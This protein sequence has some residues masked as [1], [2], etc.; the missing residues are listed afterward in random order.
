MDKIKHFNTRLNWLKEQRKTHEPV[1]ADILDYIAP[2]LKGYLNG[3]SNDG[4]RKDEMDY[5][6]TPV[7]YNNTCAAGMHASV[8]SPSRPWFR[9][10]MADAALNQF[11]A[12]RI[13]L[14]DC[15]DLIYH[16]MHDSNFYPSVHQ[17]Y[18]HLAPIGTACMMIEKDY[19][20]VIHCR[21]LN[22][23]E[24]WIG[25]NA[26]SRV[27][28]L[29][30]EFKMTA[31]QLVE[32]FGDNVPKDIRN[33]LENDQNNEYTVVHAIEPDKLGIAPFKKKY[34]SVYYLQSNNNNEFLSVGG[35]D[36]LP[37]VA[38]RWGT[39]QGEAW[40]KFCPG[41]VSIGNCKQLQ[42][43]VYDFHEGLQKINNPPLQGNADAL[44]N[45]QVVGIPGGF[46]A[47]NSMGPDQSIKPLYQVNPDI[48]ATW[49][50][51]EDKKQQIANDFFVDLFQAV[52]QISQ[53]KEMTATEVREI[54]TERMLVLGPVLEN[55]QD[56]LLN[57]M[58][59]IIWH[60]AQEAG[61]LPEMPDNVAEV[62]SKKPIKVDYISSMASAQR[63]ADLARIDQILTV[64]SNAAKLNPEALDKIDVDEVIDQGDKMIGSPGGIIRDDETVAK[65]RQ[66]RQQQLEEQQRNQQLLQA[67]QT[68]QP[69]ATAAKTL[70]E[71]EN[72]GALETMLNGMGGGG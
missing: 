6:P 71:T 42:T 54:A 16:I 33:Q 48:Q 2:D 44:E 26:K 52:S 8:T 49:Q 37:F 57:P 40:G 61:I 22:V 65:I 13:W 41:R 5:D 28:T 19:D 43:L 9:L 70:S 63:L 60:Y 35:F 69:V 46:N 31:M 53:Q 7:K 55:L 67:A 23:G 45:G 15:S 21:T 62:L 68:A 29:Y 32:A 64:V 20:N 3:E 11:P 56:E 12:V 47:T 30:R 17:I 34:V 1:W 39:N 59:D 24:Y 25:V 14:D 4:S 50:T 58:I 36:I 51:I 10:M 27:D 18:L 72:A 38:P 66:T